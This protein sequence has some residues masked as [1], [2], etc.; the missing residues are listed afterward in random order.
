MREA[1]SDLIERG[2]GDHRV[3]ALGFSED[4][5]DLWIRFLTADGRSRREFF[6]VW[7]SELKIHLDFG[8]YQGCPLVLESSFSRL[9][10]GRWSVVRQRPTEYSLSN[11]TR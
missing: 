8:A 2:L 4:G 6:F 5:E 9:D 10:K 11:A 3:E 1:K 7:V